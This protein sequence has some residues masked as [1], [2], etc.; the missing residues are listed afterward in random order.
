MNDWLAQDTSNKLEEHLNQNNVPA[1]VTFKPF[2]SSSCKFADSTQKTEK[3]KRP[4]IHIC[5]NYELYDVID[6]HRF[7]LLYDR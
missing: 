6:I 3:N 1:D 4:K 7:I 5:L 2:L